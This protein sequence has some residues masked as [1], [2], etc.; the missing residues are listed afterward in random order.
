MFVGL[1]AVAP[2]MGTEIAAAETA[3]PNRTIKIVVGF[4]AGGAK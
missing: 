4:P 1:V 3:Y 2:L